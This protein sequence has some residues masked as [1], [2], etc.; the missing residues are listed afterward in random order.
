[1][2][3]PDITSWIKA[4]Q[5]KPIISVKTPT[6]AMMPMT[7]TPHTTK[8]TQIK[9]IMTMYLINDLIKEEIVLAFLDLL[10]NK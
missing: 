9:T 2:N 5:P 1:M 3:K 10:S 4:W 6:P 7:S 8:T